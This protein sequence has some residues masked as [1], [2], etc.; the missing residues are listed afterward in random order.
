MMPSGQCVAQTGCTIILPANRA[1]LFGFMMITGKTDRRAWTARYLTHPQ[2]QIDPTI[3][4]PQWSLSPIGAARVGQLANNL[5][6]LLG[7]TRIVSSDETKAIETAEPIA[8][9]LGITL[10]IRAKMHEND[11]SATGFLVP[12]EF[13]RVA[14]AFFANPEQNVRGWESAVDAQRRIMDEVAT[15]IASHEAGDI[16]FVGHGGVGTLLMCALRNLP[17]DRQFDQGPGGGGC[18]FEFDSDGGLPTGWL[19]IEALLGD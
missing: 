13:E 10:E 17:I 18:W 5:G 16:L 14:D 19:P 7:T 9:A 11:R 6:S 1:G 2:V 3:P 4:V 8:V 12:D 15:C